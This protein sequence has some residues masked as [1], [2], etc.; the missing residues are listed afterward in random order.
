MKLQGKRMLN[1]KNYKT[2]L[3]VLTISY[4]LTL[5]GCKPATVKSISTSFQPTVLNFKYDASEPVINKTSVLNAIKN[6]IE[7]EVKK[8]GGKKKATYIKAGT[9]IRDTHG[10]TIQSSCITTSNN[11]ECQIKITFYNG[12]YYSSTSNEYSTI[13]TIKIPVKLNSIN[14]I[15]TAKVSLSGNASSLEARSPLFI[16]YKPYAT[17]R[18]LEKVFYGSST[19]KPSISFNKVFSKQIEIDADDTIVFA[20][21]KRTYGL[22]SYSNDQGKDKI[23]KKSAFKLSTQ[24]GFKPLLV[25]VYPTR[26]GSIMDYSFELIFKAEPNGTINFNP[27][28]IDALNRSILSVANM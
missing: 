22:Y 12:E 13:Q 8:I 23:G 11:D 17:S 20:N 7:A 6:D 9:N 4:A 10:Y 16:P 28:E 1:F 24:Q 27:S 21:L 15:I 18:D 25:E 26:Q 2:V 5:S 19:I 14:N 3:T